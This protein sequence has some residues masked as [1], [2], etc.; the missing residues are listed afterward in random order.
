MLSMVEREKVED[1]ARCL[2][3]KGALR[4]RSLPQ[5]YF[6]TG[7]QG[8]TTLANRRA[9]AY[10]IIRPLQTQTVRDDSRGRWVASCVS[11]RRG[12]PLPFRTSWLL[13][14]VDQRNCG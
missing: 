5:R 1:G 2:Q 13:K 9:I 10:D 3:S 7:Q 14:N 8:T 4:V 11:I 12:R 6:D